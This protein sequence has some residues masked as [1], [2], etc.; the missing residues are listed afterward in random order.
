MSSE[1]AN[2]DFAEKLGLMISTVQGLDFPRHLR[3]FI[4]SRVNIDNLLVLVFRDGMPPVN[5][6]YWIPQRDGFRF[7]EQYLRLAYNLDPFFKKA[8]RGEEGVFS[9]G[10]IAPDRFFQSEYGKSYFASVR[11][12]DELGIICRGPAESFINLSLGRQRGSGRFSRADKRFLEDVAPALIPL[13]RIY[14]ETRL[15]KLV[16]T[17]AAPPAES[18]ERR[19]YALKPQPGI[20]ASLTLREAEVIAMAMGGH[21]NAS[22]AQ[23]M[24]ISRL[25][26]KVHRKR[27]YAKL[28]VS[29][30]AE[31]FLKIMPML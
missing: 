5:L 1:W 3:A 28:Q 16:W 9:I 17:G 15:A 11:M 29:S 24:G 14:A 6:F 30:Q 21:S 31:L 27:A 19:L 25:T 20:A 7:E 4:L 13:L 26:V 12:L 23:C 8:Q 2:R 22:I 18:M 10:E